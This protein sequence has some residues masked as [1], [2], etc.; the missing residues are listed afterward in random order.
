MAQY[1]SM[2]YEKA[3][4]ILTDRE[5]EVLELV[6]KFYSSNEIAEELEISDRTVHKHKERICKK[7]RVSGRGAL[8]K[9]YHKNNN[10]L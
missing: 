7:I 4:Y 2:S 1:E 5:Q 9:W 8:V 6:G 10:R 3:L